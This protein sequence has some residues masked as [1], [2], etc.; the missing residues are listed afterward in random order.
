[1]WFAAISCSSCS[2]A[3][4]CWPLPGSPAPQAGQAAHRARPATFDTPP[5][6]RRKYISTWLWLTRPAMVLRNTRRHGS[7]PAAACAASPAAL[8]G[9]S[10]GSR[11][12]QLSP[13][14]TRVGAD[15]ADSTAALRVPAVRRVR[16]CTSSPAIVLT[17]RTAY[18]C[19]M[20]S[21]GNSLSYAMIA[22]HSSRIAGT[23]VCIPGAC[24][25]DL[26]LRPQVS[27][28]PLPYCVVRQCMRNS[29]HERPQVQ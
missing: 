21:S 3:N 7:A 1:M 29:V 15:D 20:R 25:A 10:S 22:L 23:D 5:S 16:T 24:I 18:L 6:Q 19:S 12:H 27:M 28:M 8:T 11:M 17:Q 26:I 9:H 4:A 13:T 2:A 14:H